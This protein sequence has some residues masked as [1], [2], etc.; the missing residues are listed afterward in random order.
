MF[1]CIHLYI[2][3]STPARLVPREPHRGM[4]AIMSY[5]CYNIYNIYNILCML[6]IYIIYYGL[7]YLY[8]MFAIMYAVMLFL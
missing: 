8:R 6:T 5:V 3:A 7:R 2:A 1:M 4:F